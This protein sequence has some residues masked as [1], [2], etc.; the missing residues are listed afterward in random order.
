MRMLFVPW[1]IFS[2]APFWARA[3]GSFQDLDFESANLSTIPSGQ[4]GGSVPISDALPGWTGFI[5]TNQVSTALQN[6]LTL[7]SPSIDILGPDFGFGII[8]GQYSLALQGGSGSTN[9]SASV[10]Q[11]GLVPQNA[12]S[13]QFKALISWSLVVSLGGQNLSIMPLQ[14]GENYT[15]YGANISQFAGQDEV[16]TITT[17]G[18]ASNPDY[19]DSIVFSPAAIP[20]PNPLALLLLGGLTIAWCHRRKSPPKALSSGH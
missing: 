14:T 3:Q 9:F 20:E 7:G 5:G 13:L 6:N 1:M 10:S 2:C 15:L 17:L 11:T 18:G 8:E 12:Q 4:Y 16:L 19:F